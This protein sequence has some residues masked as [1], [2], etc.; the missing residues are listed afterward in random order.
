[1]AEVN[2]L[3]ISLLDNGIVHQMSCPYTPE[4]NGM[5]E[6][7]HR[8]VT[9]LGLTMLFHG[10]VPK[11]FRVE[12]FST[13]VWLINRLPTRILDMQSPYERLLGT[14]LDYGSVRVFGTR[15]YPCLRDYA[16]AKFDARSLP[17]V[18]L[19]YSHRFKG[20]GCLYPPTN[21]IYISHHVVFDEVT[22]PFRDPGALH[23]STETPL[24]LAVFTDWFLDAWEPLSYEPL[25]SEESKLSA[26]HE[27][28]KFQTTDESTLLYVPSC[29]TTHGDN[30]SFTTISSQ[31]NTAHLE[32]GPPKL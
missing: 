22:F 23:S 32:T 25:S 6:R 18:F 15:C 3:D 7:K 10:G 29:A 24:D 4:Q 8:N 20:Y 16:K 1:M 17:C 26:S 27:R 5:A 2:L 9:E 12:S 14:K 21:R 28:R 11:H 13:A 30:S 19:G 31:S